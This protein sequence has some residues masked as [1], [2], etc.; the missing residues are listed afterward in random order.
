MA[1]FNRAQLTAEI[2]RGVRF[3][4]IGCAGLAT[5]STIFTLLHNDGSS[6]AAARAVSLLVA[7]ALTWSLNRWLTFQ[8]SGRRPAD[9]LGRYALVAMG[10]QGF[11]Y[12]LFLVLGGMY[13][14]A[15]PLLLILICAVA[16]AGISY[17]GQRL[18]TFRPARSSA[19]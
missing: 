4:C 5:D 17:S 12:V 13:P 11:N 14:A 10:A 19:P 8:R 9:E 2:W 3:A 18:F 1:T 16:A 7:T 15:S 6:R